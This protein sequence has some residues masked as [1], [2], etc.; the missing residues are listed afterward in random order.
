MSVTAPT[1]PTAS[2][3]VP[4]YVD[5]A[6]TILN[7]NANWSVF[8]TLAGPSGDPTSF[9]W[10]L[11][12]FFGRNVFIGFEGRTSSLGSGAYFAF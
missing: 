1:S 9:D 3:T 2:V 7:T 6:S 11:P 10:G 8:P 4:F 5:N 12:F